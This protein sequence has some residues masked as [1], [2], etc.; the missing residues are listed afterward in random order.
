MQRN[1]L[2][3][4]RIIK[5]NRSLVHFSDQTDEVILLLALDL[6]LRV[7]VSKLLSKRSQ[8]LQAFGALELVHVSTQPLDIL[9]WQLL[10]AHVVLVDEHAT[11]KLRERKDALLISVLLVL[12][13][14]DDFVEVVEVDWSVLV[15]QAVE[16][17]LVDNLVARDEQLLQLVAGDRLLLWI[18]LGE[19][20][21]HLF[22]LGLSLLGLL[23]E[24]VVDDLSDL[25]DQ[26]LGLL[27]KV[28]D[29]LVQLVNSTL[30]DSI[31]FTDRRL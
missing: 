21:E 4:C 17:F 19:L 8:V 25:G 3:N 13:R 5:I 24:A 30:F 9:L 22:K 15:V 6:S 29:L 12:Q 2:L 31:F 7:A 16:Q 11:S 27:V 26:L 1:Y 18:S 28:L 20:L 23:V 14:I 10:L